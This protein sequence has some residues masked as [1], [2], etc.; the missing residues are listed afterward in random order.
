MG[1]LV[2]CG[3]LFVVYGLLFMVYGYLN[4]NPLIS[5]LFK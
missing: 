2:V 1:M 3:L 5:Q 4:F